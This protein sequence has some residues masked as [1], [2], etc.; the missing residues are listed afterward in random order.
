MPSYLLS[1]PVGTGLVVGPGRCRRP[2]ACWIKKVTC[3]APCLWMQ[4]I[5][6]AITRRIVTIVPRQ[7]TGS[8]L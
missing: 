6:M 8:C 3:L 7:T 1:D 2:S 4:L 5:G